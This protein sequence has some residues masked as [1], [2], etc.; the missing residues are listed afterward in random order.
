MTLLSGLPLAQAHS[1]PPTSR[2]YWVV[3]GKFLAGAYP[4]SPDALQ[5]RQRIETLWNSGL[6]SFVNLME[7]DERNNAGQLF[8]PYDDI[9]RELAAETG[10]LNLHQRFAVR[11]LSIP[12]IETM[13]SILDSIDQSLKAD[14][15][16]Y[17]Y[18]FGGVGRTGTV[19][20]CWL[21][22]HGFAMTQNVVQL[23]RQL[24]QADRQSCNRPAPETVAQIR[25][26]EQW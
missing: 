2:C 4:G 5:H 11:D 15:P 20:C 23:L 10:G 1:D 19:V 16:V 8:T 14:R 26:V 3:T 13:Q 17:L 25:F 9:L 22:R 12:S 18:C 21:L 6:R 24:R 7:E